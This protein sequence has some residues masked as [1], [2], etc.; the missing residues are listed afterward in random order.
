MLLETERLFLRAYDWRDLDQLHAILSDPV[1]MKFWPAPFTL[2][3]SQQ[4]MRQSMEM[5]AVGFGRLGV[6]LKSDGSLIGDAGLRVSDI[7]SK[8][9]NDLGYII[10]AKYWG[11]GYGVEGAA[12]VLKYGVDKLDLKR[13]CANMPVNHLDSKK[14]AIRLGMKLEKEFKNTRNHNVLTYLYVYD[15]RFNERL[16]S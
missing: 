12:A 9:E 7:D 3:Q 2:D 1:T 14:V 13:I 10:Q 11:H 4:W 16:K 8:K 6:F 5:Y 15:A